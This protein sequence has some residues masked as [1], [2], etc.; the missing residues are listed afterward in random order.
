MNHPGKTE[1]PQKWLFCMTCQT[2]FVSVDGQCP[3]VPED[4]VLIAGAEA[5]R[6]VRAGRVCPV[7]GGSRLSRGEGRPPDTPPMI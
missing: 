6:R 5:K 3:E 2:V 1:H 4:V 7:C